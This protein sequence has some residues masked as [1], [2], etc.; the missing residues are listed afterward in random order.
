M[1]A[2][3]KVLVLTA[4]STSEYGTPGLS[5]LSEAMHSLLGLVELHASSK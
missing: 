3:G 2:L 4:E 1:A 5:D